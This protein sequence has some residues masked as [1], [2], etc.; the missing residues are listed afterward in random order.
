MRL[1]GTIGMLSFPKKS[2][3][4]SRRRDSKTASDANHH[5][6][7]W[8]VCGGN[9]KQKCESSSVERIAAGV[10]QPPRLPANP[11]TFESELHERRTRYPSSP[12][13]RPARQ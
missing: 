12:S 10:T 5:D 1:A 4:V 7:Y 6:Y 3:L 13:H 8:R 11:P 9:P 2:A